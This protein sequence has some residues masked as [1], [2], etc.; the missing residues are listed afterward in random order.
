MNGFIHNI[1]FLHVRHAPSSL[2]SACALLF[3]VLVVGPDALAT[4]IHVSPQASEVERTAAD[5]LGHYVSAMTQQEA[6]VV[7]GDPQST[8][9]DAFRIRMNAQWPREKW[10]VR[11]VDN[12]VMLEGGSRGVLY[13]VYHYL[14]DVCGVQWFTPDAEFVPRLADLPKRDLNLEGLP[15][16]AVRDVPGAR[17][18]QEEDYRFAARLRLNAM[19]DFRISDKWGGSETFGLPNRCHT[20]RLYIPFAKYGKLHPEWFALHD[21]KRFAASGESHQIAQLCLS[22]RQLREEVVRRLV[23]FIEKDRQDA[24][25]RGAA[26]PT[27]YDISQDDNQRYCQCEECSKIAAREGGNQSG[28][29]IDFINDIADSISK[30][31]PDI[32]ISTFAYQY[33]EE[34]PRTIRPRPNVLIVLCDTRGN[35]AEPVSGRSNAKFRQLLAAWSS[36]AAQLRIWDYPCAYEQQANLPVANEF[37]FAQDIKT[38]RKFGV[39]QY[40]PQLALYGTASDVGDYKRYLYGK[41]MEN[42]DL[43]FEKVS[44][45]FAHGYFGPAGDNFLKYRLLLLNSMKRKQPFIAMYPPGAGSY[46]H[47][48]LDT[49]LEAQ[50]LF[51]E[52]DKLLRDD[53]LIK[54]WRHARLSIDRA[55]LNLERPLMREHLRRGGTM[56]NYPL[57]RQELLTRVA[58]AWGEH[59][60]TSFGSPRSEGA[61]RAYL[62]SAEEMNQELA[63]IRDFPPRLAELTLPARFADRDMARVQDYSA[64]EIR[65]ER[66][67]SLVEDPDSDVGYAARIYHCKAGEPVDKSFSLPGSYE[68]YA[69]EMWGGLASGSLGLSSQNIPGPGYHWFKAGATKLTPG[70]C[71]ILW[72]WRTRLPIGNAFR[73]RNPEAKFDIWIHAKFTGPGYPHGVNDQDNA[74]YIDCIVLAPKGG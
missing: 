35:S 55:A 7:E 24:A 28:V 60:E 48:D 36:R 62:R 39:S 50:R 20:F 53:E 37:F 69:Y 22:N 52:G 29:M 51:D 71:L 5:E 54:R 66:N 26:P 70:A 46:V 19:G 18:R 3:A 21:G 63:R 6:Q 10:A 72:N 44:Q 45:C 16:L 57:N 8:Q 13:A 49:V 9:G 12:G 64:W 38:L 42:P 32:L 1:R 58:S 74:I 47:L 31:H 11:S 34:P 59:L 41:F 33:S 61:K 15:E 27:V 65:P 4:T 30:T 25:K 68:V 23:E 2:C 67:I 43:D 40:Y 17:Y 73:P 14:E 56:E